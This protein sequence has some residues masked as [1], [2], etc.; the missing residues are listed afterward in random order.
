MNR[1]AEMPEIWW[2][3][4]FLGNMVLDAAEETMG[5]AVQFVSSE[6]VV[7]VYRL[8]VWNLGPGIYNLEIKVVDRVSNRTVVT[9][10]EFRV[11][12]PPPGR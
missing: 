9:G 1:R 4:R 7:I 5:K 11:L 6:G 10:T 12:N 8:P 3:P 2:R